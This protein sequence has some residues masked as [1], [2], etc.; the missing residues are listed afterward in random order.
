MKKAEE[1][2]VKCRECPCKWPRFIR[3]KKGAITSGP[4]DAAAMLREHFRMKHQYTYSL[5]R[6]H[7]DQALRKA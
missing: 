3:N 7:S 2:Y 5:V 1:G 4:E 6:A